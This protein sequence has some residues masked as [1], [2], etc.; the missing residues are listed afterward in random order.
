MGRINGYSKLA[1]TVLFTLG[2]ITIIIIGAVIPSAIEV[3]KFVFSGMLVIEMVM[4]KDLYKDIKV[5]G[6]K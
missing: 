1:F 6:I 4:V 5:N 3:L 2:F